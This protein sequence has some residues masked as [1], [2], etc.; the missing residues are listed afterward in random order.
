M[1]EEI[2]EP[3]ERFDT[4]RDYVAWQAADIRGRYETTLEYSSEFE[5]LERHGEAFR[6]SELTGGLR[7][8]ED[9]KC[10][11]NA[12]SV[13]RAQPD[14]FRYVEGVAGHPG[15]TAFSWHAH[16][17]VVDQEDRAFDVTW[18]WQRTSYSAQASSYFG[19]LIP[20]DVTSQLLP[21]RKGRGVFAGD[22]LLRQAYPPTIERLPTER[23]R[24]EEELLDQFKQLDAAQQA[25]LL[26][27]LMALLHKQRD[28]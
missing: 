20:T 22:E 8:M 5:L 6:M 4:A 3:I 2:E 11:M 14:R 17:W 1:G 12:L 27:K 9:R 21:L 28:G 18:P 15:G 24:L 23:E 16:A 19:A 26:S 13:V 10:F 25:Q 7:I